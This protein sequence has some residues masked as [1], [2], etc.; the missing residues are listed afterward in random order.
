[1]MH[2]KYMLD[3]ATVDV[4]SGLHTPFGIDQEPLAADGAANVGGYLRWLA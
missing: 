3:D 2:A 4:M 1:M